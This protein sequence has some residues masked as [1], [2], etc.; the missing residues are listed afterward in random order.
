MLSHVSLTLALV[1]T[2]S[3][4]AIERGER[5]IVRTDVPLDAALLAPLTREVD[6]VWPIVSELFQ[7]ETRRAKELADQTLTVHLYREVDAYEEVEQRLT[8]GAYRES[9]AFSSFSTRESYVVIQ[10]TIPDVMLR[11]VGLPD[12]TL[13]LAVHEAAHAA[14]YHQVPSFA[15]FP[16]WLAEGMA[17]QVEREVMAG[18]ARIED[19][20]EIPHISHAALLLKRMAAAGRLPEIERIVNDELAD[21][22]R[23]E[24]YAIWGGLFELLR[25][26]RFARSH[27]G[28]LSDVR[29]LSGRD[30]DRERIARALEKRLGRARW[31][32]LDKAFRGYVD[33]LRPAWDETF[34]TLMVR[35]TSWT[36][37]ARS[38]KNAICWRTEPVDADGYRVRGRIEILPVPTDSDVIPQ[39][40]LLLGRSAGGFV[41]V[42]MRGGAGVT[43][44]RFSAND[45]EPWR[46]LGG[47]TGVTFE[48]GREHAFE[49]EVTDTLRVLVDGSAQVELDLDGRGMRGAFGVG[50]QAGAGGIW[51]DVTLARSDGR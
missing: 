39:M 20:M 7:L 47:S 32:G 30:G 23:S 44:L 4:D 3:D 46:T 19:R 14:S 1:T 37:L 33:A 36:Q 40:N 22:S 29:D 16:D 15:Y 6:R 13:R 51:R 42:A 17:I 48:V 28:F 8:K 34:R 11:S 21:Y 41:S 24:R 18:R 5:A 50:C 38:S 27:D 35:G 26:K 49:V 31:N 9:W 43:V 2:L 12:E 25:G 10:P 45:D